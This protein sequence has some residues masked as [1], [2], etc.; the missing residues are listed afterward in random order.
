MLDGMRA[1]Q[2]YG[3]AVPLSEDSAIPSMAE[4]LRVIAAIKL[5]DILHAR[6][7]GPCGIVLWPGIPAELDVTPRFVIDRDGNAHST[8]FAMDERD[9]AIASILQALP[10]TGFTPWV[11]ATLED[12]WIEFPM[13]WKMRLLT[14][15][16][17]RERVV[18]SLQDMVSSGPRVATPATPRARYRARLARLFEQI[19]V[20]CLVR[21]EYGETA[22]IDT[23]IADAFAGEVIPFPANI[24]TIVEGKVERWLAK[25]GIDPETLLG[26][27][28]QVAKLATGLFPADAGGCIGNAREK[29]LN[30]VFALEHH[31]DLA[32]YEQRGTAVLDKLANQLDGQF[33]RL[34]HSARETERREREVAFSQLTRARAYLAPGNMTQS[35]AMSLIHYLN[36]YGPGFPAELA[37]SIEAGDGRHHLLFVGK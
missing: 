10:E 12:T 28:V 22:P 1:G 32:G 6:S 18:C 27:D 25:Y 29:L 21:P 16:V 2:V 20:I 24:A 19:P 9:E 34:K 36:F 26:D 3:I 5:M 33:D 4:T 14:A 17:V 23:Q 15:L 30:R 8:R 37:G 35:D 31:L 7:I 13:L 11:K